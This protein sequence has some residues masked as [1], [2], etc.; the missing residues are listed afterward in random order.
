MGSI[1]GCRNTLFSCKCN[2]EK[3]GKL[4]NQLESREGAIATEH[5]DKE[6][7]LWQEFKERM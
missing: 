4:I 7:M 5:R 6:I 3:Q 2:F 1:G